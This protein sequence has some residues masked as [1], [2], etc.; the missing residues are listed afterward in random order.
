VERA[1]PYPD[2]LLWIYERDRDFIERRGR[3]NEGNTMDREAPYPHGHYLAHSL[4][5]ASLF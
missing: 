4:L 5:D 1:M 3:E 2:R